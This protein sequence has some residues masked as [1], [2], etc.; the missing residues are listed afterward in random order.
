MLHYGERECAL[1]QWMDWPG[2]AA[3]GWHFIPMQSP[4]HPLNTTMWY[5][6]VAKNV[7]IVIILRK[8]WVHKL[9]F[10]PL[11]ACLLLFCCKVSG[12]SS[13]EEN[14]ARSWPFYLG[15]SYQHHN[16]YV[17]NSFCTVLFS[18]HRCTVE[19]F[20]VKDTEERAEN[21]VKWGF[22]KFSK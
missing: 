2:D 21:Y 13:A 7:Y 5:C 10:P 1:R 3:Q 12:K 16:K 20:C 6:T 15:L 17:W 8:I 14:T 4:L 11:L 9:A 22:H 18:L 19:K